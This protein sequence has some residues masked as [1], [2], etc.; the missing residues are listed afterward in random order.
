MS[1]EGTL[2]CEE[3]LR[4]EGKLKGA[5]S[6]PNHR[7]VI[8]STGQVKANIHARVIEVE[9]RVIGDLVGVERVVVSAS[10]NVTGNLKAPRVILENGAQFKGAIDMEPAGSSAD[11]GAAQRKGPKQSVAPTSTQGVSDAKASVSVS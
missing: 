9:G 5:V 8:G 6:V 7:V 3:D 10:G 4:L 1:L 2:R 11:A